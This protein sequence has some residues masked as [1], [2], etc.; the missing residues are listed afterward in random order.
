MH[1]KSCTML[2]RDAL[3]EIGASNIKI[4]LDE[5]KQVAKVSFDGDKKKAIEVIKKEGYTIEQ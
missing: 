1:C 5:K 2:V 3:T 4:D